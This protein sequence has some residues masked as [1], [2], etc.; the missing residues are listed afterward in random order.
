MDVIAIGE[1]LIDFTP[2]GVSEQ[3]Q[4]LYERNPGGAPANVLAALAKLG[5][6]TAFIG[7]VGDDAFGA[8]LSDTLREA[9]IN[10]DQLKH[11]KEA[12]TTL[13]FVHLDESGDRS[14]TFYRRPGA[15]QF[16]RAEEIDRVA[17]ASAKLLHFGSV[18]MTDEPARSAT[19]E[20]AAYARS[21]GVMISYDPNLRLPLWKDE[22]SA[23]TVILEGMRLADIS[24]LSEEELLFLTGTDDLDKGS[25]MLMESFNQLQLLFITLGPHGSYC[26]LRTTGD[27]Q[28]PY[29][30]AR[31]AGYSVTVV[32][33][34]GS[35][36]AFLGGALY[37]IL[38]SRSPLGKEW[39]TS[40]LERML[41]FANAMGAITATGKGAIPSLPSSAEQVRAFVA[42]RHA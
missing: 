14:F 36:D 39:T 18:S 8:Y 23:R 2:Y 40:K 13:A 17:A 27:G 34:T 9:D 31:S 11:S 25:S 26:K 4:P 33:T 5:K 24:K 16:L 28:A 20:T 41:A 19:L 6:R 32:D 12:L 21:Q 10:I 7:A 42:Q 37:C 3:G 29:Q 1:V 38:D 15:D 22:A 35:G 30:S